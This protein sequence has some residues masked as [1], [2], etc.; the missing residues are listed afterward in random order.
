MLLLV[1]SLTSD[2]LAFA[3]TA[4]VSS[5]L[6]GG[7][8]HANRTL[9]KFEETVHDQFVLNGG[10]LTVTRNG[11]ETPYNWPPDRTVVRK[12]FNSFLFCYEEVT[13]GSVRYR[14]DRRYLIEIP[15][16][17]ESRLASSQSPQAA[18]SSTSP[19]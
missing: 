6:A 16:E 17:S 10:Q 14:I 3:V 19:E 4:A 5:T 7:L 2:W 8:L 12:T 13:N 1:P 18:S 11:V 15:P 9:R